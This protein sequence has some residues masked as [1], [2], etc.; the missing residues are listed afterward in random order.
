MDNRKV[1]LISIIIRIPTTVDLEEEDC[2]SN[3]NTF[4]ALPY[5]HWHTL[6]SQK[7]GNHPKAESVANVGQDHHD[8]G[9]EA[10]AGIETVWDETGVAEMHEESKGEE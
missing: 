6:S 10:E 3:N 9:D 5:G 1:E 2:D 4:A 7:A 8:H